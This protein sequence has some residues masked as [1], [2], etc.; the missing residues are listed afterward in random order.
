[1]RWTGVALAWSVIGVCCPAALA[2]GLPPKTSREIAREVRDC[3]EARP[4]DQ[5]GALRALSQARLEPNGE[6]TAP[7]LAWLR[8]LVV[9]VDAKSY[10]ANSACSLLDLEDPVSR[11][12]GA[13]K[14]A[15]QSKQVEFAREQTDWLLARKPNDRK[16]L[17]LSAE[18]CCKE[19]DKR[20]QAAT[21]DVALKAFDVAAASA[22]GSGEP[23]FRCAVFLDSYNKPLSALLEKRGEKRKGLVQAAL[24]RALAI[25]PGHRDARFMRATFRGPGSAGAKVLEDLDTLLRQTPDDPRTL[26]GRARARDSSLDLVGA[27]VDYDRLVELRPEDHYALYERSQVKE[28]LG[29]LPG[30]VSDAARALEIRKTLKHQFLS[31]PDYHVRL[32]VPLAALGRWKEA[33]VEFDA[34][35]ATG[36]RHTW[37]HSSRARALVTSGRLRDAVASYTLC[38]GKAGEGGG[39]WYQDRALVLLLLGERKLATA[40]LHASVRILAGRGNPSLGRKA[41]L[42][43]GALGDPTMLTDLVKTGG[44]FYG[45]LALALLGRAT[46]DQAIGWAETVYRAPKWRRL[47][48][49]QAQSLIG[50]WCWIKGDL[51]QARTQFEACL[52]SVG[53]RPAGPTAIGAGFAQMRRVAMAWR[54]LHP[55]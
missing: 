48:R 21:L 2:Q 9:C 27:L 29:D 1:M 22:P 30:A 12:F 36:Q 50:T 38:I 42:W 33:D 19:F 49:A 40:D 15:L 11:R 54:V 47:K 28:S 25:E 10:R 18:I 44:R 53:K 16:A 5:E 23:W 7:H 45:S 35:L 14:L 20:P 41:K 51:P 46:S 39:T 34:A 17:L 26:R 6:P 55:R 4:V 31:L 8:R 43:L 3:L 37:I 52:A 24:D 32:A 13:A